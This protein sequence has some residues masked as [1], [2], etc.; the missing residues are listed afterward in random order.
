MGSDRRRTDVA[1]QDD[2][3]EAMQLTGI[4]RRVITAHPE[5][6]VCLRS[7]DTSK[8]V[9]RMRNLTLRDV[10]RILAQRN[11]ISDVYGERIGFYKKVWALGKVP[12]DYDAGDDEDE[13]GDDTKNPREILD[14][15][16]VIGIHEEETIDGLDL[17]QP[18]QLKQFLH[19][20][21]V[22]KERE[23]Y[24][25]HKTPQCLARLPELE[26][27]LV[28]FFQSEGLATS[29]VR[30][31][32]WLAH[33]QAVKEIIKTFLGQKI[34]PDSAD[35]Y[36]MAAVWTNALNHA[37][38]QHPKNLAEQQLRSGGPKK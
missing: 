27:K 16:T 32:N 36:T 9:D 14:F 13:D 24:Y 33:F 6:I 38:V 4:E 5:S 26:D 29:E 25:N 30:G 35:F 17:Q 28:D 15:Q 7:G 20:L 34:P 37:I 1:G 19:L 12:K 22:K 10:L 21:L 11:V 2:W 23:S 31:G 3:S 18:D 8:M